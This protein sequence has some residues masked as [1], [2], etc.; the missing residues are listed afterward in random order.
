[1]ASARKDVGGFEILG[2][3]VAKVG[4]IASG[5]H[6][7][8]EVAGGCRGRFLEGVRPQRQ[9]VDIRR[10][11]VAR[12]RGTLGFE[13]ASAIR[14]PKIENIRKGNLASTTHDRQAVLLGKALCGAMVH[15]KVIANLFPAIELL[16]R[17]HGSA[18]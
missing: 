4:A 13:P 9:I 8:N 14:A 16:S 15:A 5:V 17:R 2:K 11:H 12:Q 18:W 3:M 6:M 10:E 7:D 1:M